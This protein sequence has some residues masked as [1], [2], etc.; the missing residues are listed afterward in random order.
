MVAHGEA[1]REDKPARS[2]HLRGARS[3]GRVH[4]GSADG[5]AAHHLLRQQKM[6]QPTT[7]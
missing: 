3:G 6:K 4:G 1:Q 5:G 7:S 2:S